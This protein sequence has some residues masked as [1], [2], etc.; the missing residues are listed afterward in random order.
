MRIVLLIFSSLFFLYGEIIKY[1]N[2]KPYYY[3]NQL[4]NLKA[5]IILSSPK[6]LHAIPSY[7]VESNLTQKNPYL[8]NLDIKFK[9]DE[10]EHKLMLIAK[11]FYKEID[12]D[13]LINIKN[14]NPPKNFSKVFAD[15]LKIINPI[16]SKYD[17]NSTILSFTI[18]C[19]N[20]NI[21]DFNLG[22]KEHNLTLIS[23][24]EASYYAIIPNN[25]KKLNFYYFNLKNE[26]FEKIE[27]PIKLKQDT[28]STQTELNP[29]ENNFFNLVNILILILIAFGLIIFLIYQKVWLLIFPILLSG[30]LIYKLLPK[31]EI[32]LSRNT[33]VQILPTKQSTVIYI[34]RGNEKAK[35]L[36]KLDKYTKIKINKKIGW[37]KNEDIR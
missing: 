16:S 17:E 11:K 21:N 34:S 32:I 36:N 20:C 29:E 5:K 19:K 9:A 26:K 3:K 37:V 1:Q 10:E 8:Y 12:L 22:F 6:E 7:N 25:I 33:K 4:V 2:I 15:N 30:F 27:I 14:I 28:I 31:G 23:Q 24:N 35:V 18:K 13:N